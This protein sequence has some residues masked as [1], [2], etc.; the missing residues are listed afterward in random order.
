MGLAQTV[1]DDWK[2][3]AGTVDLYDSL[4][5]LYHP[6][7]QNCWVWRQSF[8][9]N[10]G[11]PALSDAV[12]LQN[13]LPASPVLVFDYDSHNLRL[14]SITPAAVAGEVLCF[15][16]YKISPRTAFRRT[17]FAT[18]TD[19]VFGTALPHVLQNNY[20]EDWPAGMLARA[21]VYWRF[22]DQYYRISIKQVAK[23]DFTTA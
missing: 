19:W 7:A 15:N 10:S 18:R 21:F 12:P 9:F 16:V 6:S 14:V 20:D 11:L 4:N 22:F 2:N 23:F 8:K 1:K 17:R 3:Y 5:K 13:G